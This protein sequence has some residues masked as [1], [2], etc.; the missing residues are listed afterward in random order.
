MTLTTKFCNKISEQKAYRVLPEQHIL[1]GPLHSDFVSHIV[2]V[3]LVD[4]F[5]DFMLT[6]RTFVTA[7]MILVQNGRC[8]VY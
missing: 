4:A 7:A 8:L 2:S 5:N 3:Y 1:T 6:V